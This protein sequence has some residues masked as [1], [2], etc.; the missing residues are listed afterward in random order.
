MNTTFFYVSLYISFSFVYIAATGMHHLT[1]YILYKNINIVKTTKTKRQSWAPFC[2][3]DILRVL[4][5]SLLQIAIYF[6]TQ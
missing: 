1:A 6:E 5:T 2:T 3:N 4:G